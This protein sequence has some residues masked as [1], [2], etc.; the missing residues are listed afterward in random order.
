[1]FS[2][3]CV[4]LF[5]LFVGVEHQTDSNTWEKIFNHSQDTTRF[6]KLW[7]FY[8]PPRVTNFHQDLIFI[9]IWLVTCY[10]DTNFNALRNLR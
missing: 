1:M 9:S 4:A 6:T 3:Q 8:F 2:A 5:P 10:H 7:N